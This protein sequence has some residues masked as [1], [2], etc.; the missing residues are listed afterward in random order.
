MKNQKKSKKNFE[1]SYLFSL[2]KEN[3]INSN[4]KDYPIFDLENQDKININYN[5]FSNT[6]YKS[7]NHEK[8]FY[9][10]LSFL[11]NND[12]YK[13]FNINRSTRQGII[14]LLKNKIIEYIIPKFK[15][16]Y[17]NNGLFIN[18]SSSYK[19]ILKSYKKNKKAYIRIILSIKAKICLKNNFIINK[20]HQIVYQIL[21]QDDLE[22]S[23]STST[24]TNSKKVLDI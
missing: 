18:D 9:T 16:K 21:N 14:T 3:K 4:P 20:K 10:L 8:N 15:K 19:I 22:N 6:F 12:L 2:K 23:T 7:R 17:C 13:L 1:E 5:L 24:K 11:N